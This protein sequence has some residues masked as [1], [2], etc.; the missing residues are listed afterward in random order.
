[1]EN[2][3]TEEIMQRMK[4][5]YIKLLEVA[6]LTDQLA[7][8]VERKDEVSI[9]LIISM[10]AEPLERLVIEDEAI[11]GCLANFSPE[12][13]I[14]VAE[15]LNNATKTGEASCE[16]SQQAVKNAR[17]LENIITKDKVISKKVDQNRTFY[18]SFRTT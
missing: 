5:Q 15:I 7:T 8:A 18:N 9:N 12:K 16:L 3:S 17:L 4:Q 13:A 11:R 14:A 10:R 2:F 1:M 6:E